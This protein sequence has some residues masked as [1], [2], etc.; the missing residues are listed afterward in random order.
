MLDPIVIDPPGFDAKAAWT[1]C[2]EYVEQCGG[3]THEDGEVNWRAA[4]GADPGCNTC[5]ACRE[6]YWS[7]GRCQRCAKCGFEFPV[8]WWPKYSE[9][10]SDGNRAN[11]SHACADPAD[12]ER[13][14]QW[15][16]NRSKHMKSH[17][18]YQYGFLHPVKDAWKEHD[19][20]DWK[21]V[22]GPIGVY[23]K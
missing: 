9:G 10:V 6:Y 2:S 15:S 8:D 19:A 20:I 5:P 11:G 16:V 7:W 3:L 22:V 14:R 13:M 21:A 17:P 12:T 18:Y 23:P 4:F 1:E